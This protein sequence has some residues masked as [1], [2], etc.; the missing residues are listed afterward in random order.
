MHQPIYICILAG[1]DFLVWCLVF[2]CIGGYTFHQRTSVEAT[3]LKKN[4]HL[5]C[6]NV[7]KA[8]SN[9][10]M[11]LYERNCFELKENNMQMS[12]L[13]ASKG[14]VPAVA[15][16]FPKIKVYSRSFFDDPRLE[17]LN[18]SRDLT[19]CFILITTCLIVY[20]MDEKQYLH[21]SKYV[22]PAM[23]LL[24]IGFLIV[25][26]VPLMKKSSLILLQSLPEE[27]ENVEVLCNDLRKSFS[28]SISA[29]H[30][31]HVWCLVPNKV[32]ATLH[33]VF[34]DEYSYLS[35]TTAINAFLL[36]YGINHATIQPEFS[37]TVKNCQKAE[38]HSSIFDDTNVQGDCT[39]INGQKPNNAIEKQEIEED[40]TVTDTLIPYTC[41]ISCPTENCL[42]KRCCSS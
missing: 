18:L 42:K 40:S 20:F 24:T 29:L 6:P 39:S 37:C 1:I 32:Y 33:I 19:P 17:W 14:D 7:H 28:E 22:D 38:S 15:G 23:A 5:P 26:S 2:R 9:D 35:S 21:A 11:V 12:T 34:K 10:N 16:K 13:A 41:Q 4:P 31:V 8:D 36:K 30:E 27:M 3:W 25:S